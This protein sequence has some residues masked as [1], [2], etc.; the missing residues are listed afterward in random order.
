M[1]T[2]Y[3]VYD[4]RRKLVLDC[5]KSYWLLGLSG[6]PVTY[7]Q[8]AANHDEWV[9][10][11]DANNEAAGYGAKP[12]EPHWSAWLLPL[13]EEMA[14]GGTLMVV[15][16]YGHTPWKCWL[17]PEEGWLVYD[18]WHGPGKPAR[19]QDCKARTSGPKRPALPIAQ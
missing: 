4:E 12:G 18:P 6:E 5:H 14:V 16:E 19:L 7:E 11:R 8:I 3:Y 13:I 9:A 17:D 2:E 10:E 1:G 15:S